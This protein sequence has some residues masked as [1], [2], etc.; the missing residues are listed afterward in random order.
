M[1]P[2][3]P[4]LDRKGDSKSWKATGAD[5]V[6]AAMAAS[7]ARDLFMYRFDW[8]EEPTILGTE[9]SRMLGA[10]HGLEIPFVFGHFDMGRDANRLF[11]SANEPGRRDLS[12][13]MMSYWTAFARS[14]D[15]GRGDGKQPEWP[16]WSAQHEYVVLD[17]PAGGGIT[18]ASG[19]STRDTVLQSIEQELGR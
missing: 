7:G 11:T 4:T 6:A 3:W 2:R 5:E 13:A 8:D 16:R 1:G 18:R 17:T 19:V 15:P 12:A 10:S 9:L 14:G